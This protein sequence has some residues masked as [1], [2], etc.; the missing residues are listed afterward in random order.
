MPGN[1]VG[2][3]SDSRIRARHFDSSDLQTLTETVIAPNTLDDLTDCDQML[4][5]WP[6]DF[7][8]MLNVDRDFY[9]IWGAR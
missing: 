2:R 4:T 6:R 1:P 3:A 9:F 7:I 8:K 5:N